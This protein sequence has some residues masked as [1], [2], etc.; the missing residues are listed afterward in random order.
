M[1]FEKIHENI[2]NFIKFKRNISEM[3]EEI[4]FFKGYF[5]RITNLE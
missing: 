3:K 1:K 4:N 2:M 5:M